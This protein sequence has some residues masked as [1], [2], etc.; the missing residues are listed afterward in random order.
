MPPSVSRFVCHMWRRIHF[1]ILDTFTLLPTSF[2][3]FPLI[4][5]VTCLLFQKREDRRRATTLPTAICCNFLFILFYFGLPSS[6][7]VGFS[8]KCTERT[9]VFL[10]RSSVSTFEGR[11]SASLPLEDDIQPK[12]PEFY[13]V[14]SYRKFFRVYGAWKWGPWIVNCGLYPCHPLTAAVSSSRVFPIF[15]C[16]NYLD[17]LNYLPLVAKVASNIFSFTKKV[18]R[19]RE[20]LI[21]SF[22]RTFFFVLAWVNCCVCNSVGTEKCS[23]ATIL[24]GHSRSRSWLPW[25]R[26]MISKPVRKCL[27]RSTR[28]V[29]GFITW[30][31]PP[32]YRGNRGLSVVVFFFFLFHLMANETRLIPPCRWDGWP[33]Y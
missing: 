24:Q 28:V 21:K 27:V 26:Q 8:T 19:E 25:K 11:F 20:L 30:N 22:F 33:S 31:R 2:V 32:S 9:S 7:C 3:L 4:W 29:I 12:T 23:S 14:D 17:L 5:V 18:E 15:I 16:W 6:I 1:V 13:Y 10:R